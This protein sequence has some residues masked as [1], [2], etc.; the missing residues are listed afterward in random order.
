[1]IKNST[2]VLVVAVMASGGASPVAAQ[3]QSTT[4]ALEEIIVTARKREEFIQDVPVS[5]T[6]LSAAEL[7]RSSLRDLRDITAYVPNLLVNKVTALQGGASIA[8]RG[9]SYQEIDK[10]LDPGIGVLLDEVYLG[11]NA[12]Q[13]WKT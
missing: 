1:M 10:A 13:I 6:A 7:Q 9:V 11:T 2:K 5:V 4:L 3:A 8:I 12:G